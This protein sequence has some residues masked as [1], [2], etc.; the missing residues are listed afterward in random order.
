VHIPAIVL[1]LSSTFLLGCPQ[2]YAETV[3]AATPEQLQALNTRIQ[4]LQVQ[5]HTTRSEYDRLQQL[6][7]LSE[8]EIGNTAD[9]LSA[10]TEELNDK[11]HILTDLRNR[12]QNQHIQL[13]QQ[14][15]ILAQQIRAAYMVGRQDYLKLWLNQQDPFAVGRVL[16]YYDYF[17]RARVQQIEIINKSL[18]QIQ[19]LERTIQQQ[20]I[21]LNRVLSHQGSKREELAGNYQERQQILTQL[22]NT[23]EA[24]DQELKKLQEDKQHLE[25]LL[26][27]LS[28]V[29]KVIP[30]PASNVNFAQLKGQLPKPTTG[31]VFKQFGESLI[32]SLKSQGMIFKAGL[33]D[34]VNAV[35]AGRVVFAQWFRNYGNLVILDHQQGYMSLYAHNRSLYVKAG[36]WVEA[37]A[38]LA[39][40]G[41][42]GGR[43]MAALYFEI[44][45]QGSPVNPAGWLKGMN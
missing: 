26:G 8:E 15:K 34:K 4:A 33:G 2:A 45:Y 19:L 20:T 28:E 44:R 37:G 14:R 38:N 25:S 10:L 42:S 27:S 35:A 5:R 7:Q 32:G 16:G 6:L 18:E 29:S 40:V 9:K 30:P 24:Q 36:D 31:Q 41:D 22:A 17:N 43:D 11:Q 13:A 1:F 23:L 3:P 21:E 12:Q 39:T